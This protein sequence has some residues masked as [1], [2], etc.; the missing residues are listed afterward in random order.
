VPEALLRDENIRYGRPEED[1]VCGGFVTKHVGVGPFGPTSFAR[2]TLRL[3][4]PLSRRGF[5]SSPK[6]SS[7][8]PSSP[9]LT[10]SSLLV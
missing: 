1:R 4:V 2:R 9:D 6:K 3:S 5:G 10:T 7:T 8:P